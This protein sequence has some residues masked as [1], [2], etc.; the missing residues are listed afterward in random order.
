MSANIREVQIGLRTWAKGVYPLEAGVELLIRAAEAA[1][2]AAP[3]P[4]SRRAMI[5]AG[6][7]SMRGSSA[8]STSWLCQVAKRGC[9]ESSLPC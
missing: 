9:C 3:S 7:G 8:R 2:P 4:G 5:R 1:S 6:G